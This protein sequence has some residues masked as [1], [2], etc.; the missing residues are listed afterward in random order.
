MTGV[1]TELPA[2]RIAGIGG[3]AW[4]ELMQHRH[5]SARVPPFSGEPGEAVDLGGI[6]CGVALDHLFG[7]INDLPHLACHPHPTLLVERFRNSNRM[8]VIP[9]R[10]LWLASPESITPAEGY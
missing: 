4:I 8:R 10:G 9:G 2:H 5:L 6:D 7:H 1:A 3:P